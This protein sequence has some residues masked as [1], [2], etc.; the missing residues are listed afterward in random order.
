MEDAMKERLQALLDLLQDIE[1]TSPYRLV[2]DRT[3]GDWIFIA[4]PVYAKGRG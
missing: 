3:S 1:A 2:R 4:S